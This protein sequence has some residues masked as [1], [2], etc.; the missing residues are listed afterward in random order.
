MSGKT[1][2]TNAKGR[3]EKSTVRHQQSTDGEANNAEISTRIY[4][5]NDTTITTNAQ[6]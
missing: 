2:G 6:Q 1:E 3:I 5:T 4:N